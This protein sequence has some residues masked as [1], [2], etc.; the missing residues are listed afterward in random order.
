[1]VS[2]I[3]EEVDFEFK[4]G[5]TGGLATTIANETEVIDWVDEWLTLD[6]L[7]ILSERNGST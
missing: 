2:R 3:R 5:A 4:V 7:R 1:M 6:G